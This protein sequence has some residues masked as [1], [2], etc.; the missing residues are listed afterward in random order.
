MDLQSEST[1]DLDP[2]P[3][4]PINSVVELELMWNK[5]ADG[6]QAMGINAGRLLMDVDQAEKTGS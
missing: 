4:E 2:L 5:W 1:R 6:L 3:N